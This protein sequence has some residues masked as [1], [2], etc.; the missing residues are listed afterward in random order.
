VLQLGEKSTIF[1]DQV[2]KSNQ[3]G[4]PTVTSQPV[5]VPV[6]AAERL[7]GF[8]TAVD[9]IGYSTVI[10]PKMAPSHGALL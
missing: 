8:V 10:R 6:S 5:T 3:I 2:L 7:I 1:L 4:G 9:L